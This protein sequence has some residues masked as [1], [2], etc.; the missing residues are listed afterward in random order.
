MIGKEA[1]FQFLLISNVSN[2]CWQIE[3]AKLNRIFFFVPKIDRAGGL[4][5]D[6][7]SSE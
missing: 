3:R 7:F 1:V 6:F 4:Q 5:A 2:T